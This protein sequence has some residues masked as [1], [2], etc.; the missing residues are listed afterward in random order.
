MALVRN[1]SKHSLSLAEGTP[2]APQEIGNA[3]LSDDYNQALLDDGDIIVTDPYVD[4]PEPEGKLV[5]P[6]ARVPYAQDEPAILDF[7][8]GSAWTVEA[9]VARP[10]GSGIRAISAL[11]IFGHSLSYGETFTPDAWHGR[12]AS[13]LD[14]EIWGYGIGGAFGYAS[15]SG[16]SPTTIGDGGWPQVFQVRDTDE[17]SPG[18]PYTPGCPAI[19]WYGQNDLPMLGPSASDQ[20]P[21]LHA[22]RAMISRLCCAQVWQDSHA[23]VTKTGTWSTVTSRTTN[24]GSSRIKT[25]AADN[26]SLTIAIPDDV[27]A[28]YTFVAFFVTESDG[29]GANLNV[30]MSGASAVQHDTRNINGFQ[31]GSTRGATGKAGISA[32]RITVGSG[33]GRTVTIAAVDAGSISTSWSFDSWGIEAS[34]EPLVIVGGLIRP[35][36]YSL[37][38]NWPFGQSQGVA[39]SDVVN[40]N[41]RL[42][43]VV[44]EFGDGVIWWDAD[45]ALDKD[46]ALFDTDKTHQNELGH[47]ALALDLY[48]IL[49]G[50]DAVTATRAMASGGRRNIKP[51]VRLQ[52]STVQSIPAGAFGAE[53]SFDT[54]LGARPSAGLMWNAAQPSRVIARRGGLYRFVGCVQFA[55]NATSYRQVWLSLNGTDIVASTVLVGSSATVISVLQCEA[56]VLLLPGDTIALVAAQNSGGALNVQS[57]GKYSPTLSITRVGD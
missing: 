52:R 9:G 50:H 46:A 27:P 18:A 34:P 47:Q 4:P 31:Y 38:P 37:W 45:E 32:K 56:E 3:D 14:L 15:E 24:G 48:D 39:D 40:W 21:F 17:A 55:A 41:S 22:M 28:G 33:T 11:E 6:H 8:D 19:I 57:A 5:E 51:T 54:V 44:D 29:S 35:I 25:I 2:L 7:T 49:S 1:I 23:S 16:T 42:E 36:D 13:A 30:T 10:A 26:G 53:I 20:A 12:L 43:A